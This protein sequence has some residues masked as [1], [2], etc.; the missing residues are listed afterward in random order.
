MTVQTGFLGGLVAQSLE[1]IGVS[2][3]YKQNL[4]EFFYF[5]FIV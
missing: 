1:A 2:K 3:A 5:K 4:Y